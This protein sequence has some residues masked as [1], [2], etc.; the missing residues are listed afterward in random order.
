MI[1]GGLYLEGLIQG[2]AYM[3]RWTVFSN[4]SNRVQT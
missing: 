2:G 1:L 3:D 4:G